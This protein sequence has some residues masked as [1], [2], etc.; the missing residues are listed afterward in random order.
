M[1][2]D[3]QEVETNLK[4]NNTIPPHLASGEMVDSKSDPMV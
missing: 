3:H 2:R 4:I 1:T